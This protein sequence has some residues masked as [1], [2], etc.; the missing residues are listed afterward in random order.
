MLQDLGIIS[1]N[2]TPSVTEIADCSPSEDDCQCPHRATEPPPLVT[3][4]PP[5]L[6]DGEEDIPRMRQWL[7]DYYSTTVFNTCEHQALPQMT[8]EPLRIYMDPTAKPTCVHNPASGPIHWHDQ[9]KHDLDRDVRLGVLEKVPVNTPSEW[10]S[11]M[12][13]TAKANGKPRRTVDMQ[14]Q[15]RASVR[16]THPIESP[17]TLASRIP[18]NKW[19]CVFDSWNSYHSIPIHEDDKNYTCFIT[20]WGWYRYRVA[21][22]GYLASGDG[23]NQRYDAILEEFPNKERCVDDTGTYS[24]TIRLCFLD[25]CRYLDICARNNVILV[26]EKFQFCEPE[27]DFAGLRVTQTGIKPS[28]RLIESIMNFP[29]H[30]PVYLRCSC[31]VWTCRAGLLGLL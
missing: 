14:A 18:P 11:R 7:I 28:Q 8:G 21:P 27:I 12:V 26:P 17:F 16:Q 29:T 3:D 24:D 19:Y 4:L 20:P 5:H 10:C 6:S 2:L 25:A 15:N 22:Q 23:F 13:V 1:T 30:P 31:L 9:V